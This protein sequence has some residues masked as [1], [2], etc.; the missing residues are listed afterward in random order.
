[1]IVTCPSCMTKFKL[2]ESRLPAKGA[3]VRCSRC[4]HVFFLAPP[5][6]PRMEE[7]EE[8]LESFVKS[9]AAA[10]PSE[11]EPEIPPPE[12]GR[13]EGVGFAEEEEGMRALKRKE[14]A[15]FEE[16][17][18]R[19][20]VTPGP[21]FEREERGE[22]RPPALQRTV[23]RE[24]RGFP[25]AILI[26][27][28]VILLAVGAF[29]LWKELGQREGLTS[30]IKYPVQKVASLWEQIFEARKKGLVVADL[31]RYDEKVG[32]VLLSVIEGKVKNQSTVARQYIK[33]RVEIFDRN[34]E[35]ISEKET[36]CGLN[37]GPVGLRSLPPEFFEGEMLI[38][39]Q[40]PK[41]LIVPAGKEAPFMV[42]FKDLAREAR[43]FKVEISEAPRLLGS[44]E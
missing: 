30:Y 6:G 23:P 39:P 38:E 13:T 22:P 11:R 34:R 29:F 9:E 10:E 8:V 25:V 36:L 4:R 32:E 1:M 14:E 31:N 28:F 18:S 21:P 15:F 3:K 41:D 16:E 27:L 7:R 44:S 2:D 24:R 37:I 12:M 43:E 5:S 40:E 26:I 19:G 35:K 33:I 17:V 42:V 20:K